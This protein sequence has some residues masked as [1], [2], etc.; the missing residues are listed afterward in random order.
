MKSINLVRLVCWMIASMIVGWAN[1]SL[2]ECQSE[3]RILG[4]DL[5]GVKLAPKKKYGSSRQSF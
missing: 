4:D 2:A 1:Q 3:I 5:A